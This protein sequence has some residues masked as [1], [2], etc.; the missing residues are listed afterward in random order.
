MRR[1]GLRILRTVISV[2]L[3]GFLM[4]QTDLKA[5]VRT[6]SMTNMLY[7]GIGFM[8]IVLNVV[9]SAKKW[10]IILRLRDV[11]VPFSRLLGS[12]FV[13]LFAG[14]F[15]PSRYG[16]DIVRIYDVAKSAGDGVKAVTSVLAER[17]SG[18]IVLLV[19]GLIGA[20][21]SY[22]EVQNPRILLACGVLLGSALIFLATLGTNWWVRP[23]GFFGKVLKTDKL[24][25]LSREI[26]ESF[27]TWRCRPVVCVEIFLLSIAFQ[28]GAILAVFCY[29]KALGLSVPLT[30]FVAFIPVVYVVEAVPISL[31]GLGIREGAIVYLFGK[32][33][34]L[35]ADAFSLAI[36]VFS[37]RLLLSIIGGVV[38]VLRGWIVGA[39]GAPQIAK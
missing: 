26:G 10:D 5:V 23:L 22:Q 19:M 31:N 36:L 29:G 13:S 34:I 3:L 39:V 20:V 38:F 24:E 1:T 25:R 27:R 6:L 37:M 30:V 28:F 7:I 35:A 15:L 33:G 2:I 21:M 4:W 32:V 11:E 9:M 14:N 18:F 16:G 17:L 8:L 12:Y